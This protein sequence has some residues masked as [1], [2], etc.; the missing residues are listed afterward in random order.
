MSIEIPVPQI[1]STSIDCPRCSDSDPCPR[2]MKRV[3][4]KTGNTRVIE[5]YGEQIIQDET[6]SYLECKR[7]GYMSPS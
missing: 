3:T 4:R 1:E 6:E 7:C 2:G 5:I